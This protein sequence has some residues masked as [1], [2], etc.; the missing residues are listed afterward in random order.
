M[1]EVPCSVRIDKALVARLD[2]VAAAMSARA[3]GAPVKRSSAIRAALER[4]IDALEAEF[5]AAQ[6]KKPKK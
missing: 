1:T 6:K 3:A 2:A 4:G 5:G